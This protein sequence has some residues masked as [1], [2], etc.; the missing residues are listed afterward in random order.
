MQSFFLFRHESRVF[1]IFKKLK[2]GFGSWFSGFGILGKSQI[3]DLRTIMRWKMGLWADR[4]QS[5]RPP[6][7]SGGAP[8][9]NKRTGTF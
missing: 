1:R 4:Y 2:S 3:Y 7:V 5:T 8:A 9:R 6:C